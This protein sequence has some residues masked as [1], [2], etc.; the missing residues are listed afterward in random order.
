MSHIYITH[1]YRWITLGTSHIYVT[2]VYRRI[3]LAMSHRYDE[4][5]VCHTY[6]MREQR[7]VMSHVQ[8]KGYTK[9]ALYIY[10]CLYTYHECRSISHMHNEGVELLCHTHKRR[11]ILNICTYIYTCNQHFL[12]HTHI[13]RMHNEGVELLCHTYKQKSA[14]YIYACLYTYHECRSISHMTYM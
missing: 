10:A 14:L 4:H 2:H 12:C 6:I 8:T 3:T 5:F 11:G 1:I 9:Y 13:S 7:R